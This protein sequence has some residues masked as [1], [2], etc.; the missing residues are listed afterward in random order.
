MTRLAEAILD[1]R[2]QSPNYFHGRLLTAS[3]LTAERDAH[4]ARQRMLGRAIGPGVV[5]GLW[6]EPDNASPS[7]EPV[8]KITAGFA[9]N[10]EG[11]LLSLP[12]DQNLSLTEVLEES[13]PEACLFKPCAPPEVDAVPTGDGF[14]LLLVSPTSKFE[15]K[16]PMRSLEGD[17][18]GADCGRKWAVPG[19]TFRLESFDP[20]NVPGQSDTTRLAL[21]NLVVDVPDDAALSRLRNLVAH[22]CFGTD[23][24][25][26]YSSDPLATESSRPLLSGYGTV[27]YLRSLD[28]VTN[29]DV[30]LALIYWSGNG[31]EIVDCWA[32]RRRPMAAPLSAEWPSLDGNRMRI[33]NEARLFQFQEHVRG[34]LSSVGA[35]SVVKAQAYFRFLPAAGLLPLSTPSRAGFDSAAFFD[36]VPIRDPIEFINGEQLR[37]IVDLSWHHEPVDLAEDEMVWLYQPWQQ[38]E[39]QADGTTDRAYLLFTSAHLPPMNIP[40]FDVARWDYS[41]YARNCC[42]SNDEGD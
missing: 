37:S 31:L 10:A 11:Q 23:E 8:V 18:A 7:T 26:A 22:L 14:Y 32:V 41:N 24:F 17:K 19:V 9:L 35:P 5:E 34:L 38:Q 21:E 15:E 20:L 13:T 12:D 27:D 2:V 33:E 36:A 25:G 39:A 28:I 30:P 4:L 16:A 3:D 29:C 42:A 6:I 1:R 40:R